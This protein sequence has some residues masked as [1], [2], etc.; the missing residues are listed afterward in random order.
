M[1]FLYTMIVGSI[2]KHHQ[3]LEA[4]PHQIVYNP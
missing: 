4:T 2:D 3:W 1:L